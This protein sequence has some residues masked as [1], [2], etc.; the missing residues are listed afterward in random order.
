[1]PNRI[2]KESICTSENLDNLS[3]EEERFFYRLMVNC[4]DY[5][6]HD[7]RPQ[8]LRAKCFPLKMDHITN[9]DIESWLYALVREKLIILYRVGDKAYLQFVTWER[10]Q[11]IR[12]K[13]SKYPGPESEGACLISNDI[14]C[15]QGIA[16]VPVIQSNP[17]QK[18]SR[19][20]YVKDNVSD[21]KPGDHPRAFPDVVELENMPPITPDTWQKLEDIKIQPKD[22]QLSTLV[23]EYSQRYPGQAKQWGTRG[24]IAARKHF[25]EVVNQ[26]IEPHD[27]LVE[28]LF[29][30]P[31]SPD[32]PEPKPWEITSGLLE[33]RGLEQT[34]AQVLYSMLKFDRE[35][36][37]NGAPR[38]PPA[39]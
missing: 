16:N 17:I 36:G 5:G 6:R 25:E 29:H 26:G 30:Q 24:R 15:K 34:P 7:A 12:A 14:N 8:I 10:H 38:D 20:E 1:M 39:N 18:E 4:D 3:P 23:I 11:Q 13:K 2:I 31:D 21:L 19:K 22:K 9:E 32:E 28:I 37:I 27:I 33:C 35:V